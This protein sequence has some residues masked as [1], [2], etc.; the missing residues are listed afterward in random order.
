MKIT[1]LLHGIERKLHCNHRVDGA[2]IDSTKVVSDLKQTNKK[3][4]HD[5]CSSHV[6]GNDDADGSVGE[7]GCG[8]D[9]CTKRRIY[10]REGK[11]KCIVCM[12]YS[13]GNSEECLRDFKGCP[14]CQAVV[15]RKHWR[16]FDHNVVHWIR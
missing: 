14:G 4:S 1:R 13:E 9:N 5:D 16:E 10:I 2:S 6:D 12:Y 8:N 15:C 3:V 11:A 7:C